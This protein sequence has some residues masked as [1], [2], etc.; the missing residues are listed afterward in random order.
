M[1]VWSEC[2]FFKKKFILRPGEKVQYLVR[3]IIARTPWFSF[4]I[5][6]FL[7]VDVGEELHN[8]PRNYISIGLSGS[9]VEER[10]SYTGASREAFNAPV[11]YTRSYCAPFMRRISST[12]VHRITQVEDCWTVVLGGPVKHEWG[13]FER[14]TMVYIPVQKYLSFLQGGRRTWQTETAKA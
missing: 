5:H 12:T 3:Y 10:V 2:S 14:D 9:Y 8:H 7:G 13:F 4:Y 11:Y 6:H 1:S